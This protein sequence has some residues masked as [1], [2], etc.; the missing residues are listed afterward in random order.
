MSIPH[1]DDWTRHFEAL[2]RGELSVED[3]QEFCRR[4][5]RSVRG[6][7]PL[8]GAQRQAM[9]EE[10][11]R[12]RLACQLFLIQSPDFEALAARQ[13]TF[14]PDYCL[15]KMLAASALNLLDLPAPSLPAVNAAEE[16]EVGLPA[17]TFIVF[18][19]NAVL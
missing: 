16:F 12:L 13:T 8:E 14:G 15:L 18:G 9:E 6:L 10:F 1:K 17:T 11:D 7:P 2:Q 3:W 4:S 5:G 19:N